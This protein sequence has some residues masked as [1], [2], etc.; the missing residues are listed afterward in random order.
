MKLFPRIKL[1]KLKNFFGKSPRNLA[2]HSFTVILLLFI[3]SLIFGGFVYYKYV[4]LIKNKEP[5][6]TQ[7]PL[8]VDEK[9]FQKILNEWQEREKRF[10]EADLKEYPDPFKSPISALEELTK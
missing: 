3:F 8:Q 5:Q 1:N 9:T 10:N 2:V 4:F 7:K 6:I